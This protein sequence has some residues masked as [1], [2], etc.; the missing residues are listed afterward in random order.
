MGF[1]YDIASWDAVFAEGSS[2]VL[3]MGWGGAAPGWF[4]VI[5][6][7]LCVLV[8]IIGNSKEHSLYKKSGN[9]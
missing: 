9:S 8:L 1:P 7:V 3:F 2:G 5:G 4:T 6:M